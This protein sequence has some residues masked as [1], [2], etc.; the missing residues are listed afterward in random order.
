MN[1]ELKEYEKRAKKI[2]IELGSNYR[3]D[4]LNDDNAP[5]EQARVYQDYGLKIISRGLPGYVN[6]SAEELEKHINN[7]EVYFNEVKV[8][9]S[10][11]DICTIGIWTDILEELERKIPVI[12]RQR[13]ESKLVRKHCL[14]LMETLAKPLCRNYVRKIND[15]L[16]FKYYSEDSSRVNNCGGYETDYHY[17]IFEN[18]KEVFHAIERGFAKYSFTEYKAGSWELEIKEFLDNLEKE[19]EKESLE[20]GQTLLKELKSLK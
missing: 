2:L 4:D 18:E 3:T 10:R 19:K 5:V 1:N 8:V 6:M 14:E 9:D 12:L 17:I 20:K 7:I 16:R 15:N 13:E 11:N